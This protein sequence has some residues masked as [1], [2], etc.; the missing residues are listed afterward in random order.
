MDGKRWIRVP[1]LAPLTVLN[2]A[3]GAVMSKFPRSTPLAGAPSEIPNFRF[4]SIRE[5]SR[6]LGGIS[7]AHIYR[8]AADGRLPPLE[9]ISSGRVGYYVKT[10]TK[11]R[12]RQEAVETR[13][14]GKPGAAK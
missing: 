14:D 10:L 3:K 6:E 9:R 11:W 5:V 13:A 7:R 1:T 2:H 8:M 4:I 12:E